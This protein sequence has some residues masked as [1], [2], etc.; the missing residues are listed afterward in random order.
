MEFRVYVKRNAPFTRT[1]VTFRRQIPL[2]R[3]KRLVDS[4]FYHTDQILC[5][6]NA[7]SHELLQIRH[8][9]FTQLFYYLNLFVLRDRST[10]AAKQ[11]FHLVI[12]FVTGAKNK[13]YSQLK[14][15]EF[16]KYNCPFVLPSKLL[17]DFSQHCMCR[18]RCV[19]VWN[20]LAN[21]STWQCRCRAIICKC[22]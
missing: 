2:V 6:P 9:G 12:Q 3:L 21:F 11:P 5:I 15:C 20:I 1:T 7:I 16:N 8:S 19:R 10:N 22:E 18:V 17:D 4:A 13:M 14:T